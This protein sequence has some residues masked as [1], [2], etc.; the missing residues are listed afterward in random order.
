MP[1]CIY[2]KKQKK[3]AEFSKR[4]HVIPQSFG[5]FN[6][7]NLILNAKK[8]KTKKVCDK[9]NNEF[10]KLERWLARDSYEGHVMRSRHGKKPSNI[11]RKRVTMTLAE[12]EFKGLYV[13]ILDENGVRIIPQIGYKAK[14]NKWHYIPI[15]KLNHTKPNN[16][17]NNLS[18]DRLKLRAFSLG[19]DEA[20]KAFKKLNIN[21]VK[22]GEL[23]PPKTE[24]CK[25]LIEAKVDKVLR[26]V[27]AKIAFN[28]LAYFNTKNI[29][30]NGAFDA[31]R[32]FIRDGEDD[33]QVETSSEAILFDEIGKGY[34]IL[35]H[36]VVV[37]K[38][39]NDDVIASVS[40][41]NSLRYDVLLAHNFKSKNLKTGMGKFFNVYDKKIHDIRKFDLVGLLLPDTSIIIPNTRIITFD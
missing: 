2:C 4:E 39:E 1:I 41:Y 37:K 22:E 16:I 27:I 10:S 40:L 24:D 32:K 19:H 12:G 6:P 15:D 13:E 14:N 21:F 17:K 26:R 8:E 20:K 25:V 23:E 3:I 28:F 31:C 38:S 34:R 7:K 18:S 33:L 36:I 5:K 30:L 29:I 35:G 11:E 9:C